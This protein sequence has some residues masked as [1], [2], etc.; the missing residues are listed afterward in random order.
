APASPCPRGMALV[1]EGARRFCI[2]AYEASLVE[3]AADGGEQ[4]YPPYLP[5]DGRAVRAVSV[6][7][8]IPQA[9]ISEIQASE[10]CAASGKR[11]CSPDEWKTACVG[12][13]HTPFPYGDARRPGVCNDSGKSAVVA[14][15]GAQA[16]AASTP[17]PAV[18]A[19]PR[20]PAKTTKKAPSPR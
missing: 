5:V 20:K 1:A 7:G 18:T 15:F 2:D 16:V 10:A 8:A 17:H 19:R 13:T 11:L 6:A 9:Y 14:V 4:P 12:P 3:A